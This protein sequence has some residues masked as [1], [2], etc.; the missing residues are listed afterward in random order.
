[1]RK[2]KIGLVLGSGGAKGLSHIG[3]L[4]I[5]EREN[6]K[7]DC[8]SGSSIGAIIGS[9]YAKGYSS[10]DLEDIA[11]SISKK[12]VYEFIDFSPSLQ[13]IIKGDKILNFLKNF[14]GD[15]EFSQ[16]KI[17]FLAVAVD[18][19]TGEKIVFTKGKVI[20]AI[21][22]SISIPV[23]FQPYPCD[24]KFLIDGGVL[25]PLPVEE[26]KEYQKPDLIIGVNLQSPPNWSPKGK[27]IF[28]EIPMEPRGFSEKVIYKLT[29]TEIFKEIQKR[30]NPLFNPSLL[31]VLMQTINI[32]NWEIALRNIKL[33]D[34]VINPKVENYRTFDFDKGNELIK[35]GESS[36]EK[37]LPKLKELIKKKS[38][39]FLWF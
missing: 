20:S 9:F 35:I 36:A 17:P 39:R 15:I 8:I 28:P 31:E 29:Q 2:I 10:K 1:M 23:I 22:G 32:M 11:L 3:V 30:V 12:D 14:L 5:L 6:I 13:G 34:I 25:S 7:I 33:A 37:E 19:I 24:N 4:K 18:L 38:K 27:N 16:L 21:R 26:L